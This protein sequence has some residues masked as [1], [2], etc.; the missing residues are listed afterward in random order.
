MNKIIIGSLS[1]FVLYVLSIP[2]NA[3]SPLSNEKNKDQ[4]IEITADQL[5]ILQPNRKAE[6]RGN[7]IAQQ[8]D[9]I[10]KSNIMTV[11]YR[12]SEERQNNL[13]AVS[14][15]EVNQNVVLKTPDESAK[16]TRGVY[17]VDHQ[18][19]QLLGNV[20]LARGNNVL[21]GDRLDYNLRTQKSLL[22]ST[23]AAPGSTDGRVKGVFIPGGN[24]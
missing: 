5:E 4:P 1:V 21:K 24:P 13:G 12:T 11:Y 20:M 23:P 18:Q 2:A 7:V 8:G 6:F 15:I 19:I 16:A 14:K 17:D 10:L 3:Q 22:T 9:V